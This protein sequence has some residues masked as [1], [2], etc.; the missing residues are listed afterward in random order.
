MPVAS[1]DSTVVHGQPSVPTAPQPA[2][3]HQPQYAPQPQFTPQ[4]QYAP[5]QYGTTQFGPA[6]HQQPMMP[7][8]Q[9]F[10][11][12]GQVPYYPT[13]ARPADRRRSAGVA[14]GI[15]FAVLAVYFAIDM[16][17][18]A[19][20][21]KIY[22]S[23]AIDDA[24]TLRR[25]VGWLWMIPLLVLV[26]G[27]VASADRAVRSRGA[28]IGAGLL[29][30][31]IYA[32][33]RLAATT[34]KF[35]EIVGDRD[36]VTAGFRSQVFWILTALTVAALTAAWVLGHRR[37]LAGLIV[38]PF[39]GL[40]AY[41]VSVGLDEVDFRW[42]TITETMISEAAY[43]AAFIAVAVV[44]CWIAVGIDKMTEPRQPF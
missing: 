36:G 10:N 16:A 38:A 6:P 13:A 25:I 29:A 31:L 43:T 19:A 34:D 26:I 35:W 32:V 1:P 22:E 15:A 12:V 11:Q 18:S 30:V 17:T 7:P 37:S 3:V 33:H 41:G 23:T 28:S 2:P 24:E 14:I 40:A 8:S 27:V 21:Y 39:A 44:F 9:P 5:P 20:T 42:E 4:P